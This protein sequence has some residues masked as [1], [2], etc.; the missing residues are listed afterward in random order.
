MY[1]SIKFSCN[2]SPPEVL[3]V[4]TTWDD[5]VRNAFGK[6]LTPYC[7][8]FDVMK[9]FQIT[10]D[11]RDYHD[12]IDDTNIVVEYF[13]LPEDRCRCASII[14]IVG[15]GVTSKYDIQALLNS[16]QTI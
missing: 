13:R 14:A 8:L 16:L 7:S 1:L 5:V 3:F 15:N 12:W 4:S 10:R 9:N 2:K 6:Y 11:D